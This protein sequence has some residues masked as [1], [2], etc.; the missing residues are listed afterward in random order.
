MSSVAKGRK[1]PPA[2]DRVD[3]AEVLDW[4][5][6]LLEQGG[7]IERMHGGFKACCPAHDDRTPSLSVKPGNVRIML[8]CF[9]GCEEEAVCAALGVTIQDLFY[10]HYRRDESQ[11]VTRASR[12]VKAVSTPVE[13]E[14]A[15]ESEA[16]RFEG[17]KSYKTM[18]FPGLGN[19][20]A[21]YEYVGGD[22][23]VRYV[24][25]RYQTETG[26]SFRQFSPAS[27]G[28]WFRRGPADSAKVLY[29]LPA[30]RAGIEAGDR[31]ILVEGEKD[32]E[33]VQEIYV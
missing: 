20:S 16:S 32:A 5:R 7:R 14:A 1:N 4:V 2:V 10:E 6:S 33:S 30:L 3:P 13:H 26:K 28:R 31:V 22:G 29:R 21:T 11:P 19:P 18:G 15:P 27:D 12:P 17:L 9:A 8:H 24:V 25:A 23:V